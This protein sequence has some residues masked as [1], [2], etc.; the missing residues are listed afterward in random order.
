MTRQDKR[1][2]FISLQRMLG[3]HVIQIE[4]KKDKKV[5]SLR[6]ERIKTA[7][8]SEHLEK[9]NANLLVDDPTPVRAQEE[10]GTST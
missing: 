5:Y 10:R 6:K 3:L 1:I 4:K 7:A 8:S 9:T 2:R